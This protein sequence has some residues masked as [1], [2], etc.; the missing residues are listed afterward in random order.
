M[1]KVHFFAASVSTA[2]V[3]D[4]HRNR[5]RGYS[6]GNGHGNGAAIVAGILGAVVIGSLIAN[7]QPA[8]AAPQQYYEPQPQRYHEPQR[9]Q[10]YYG[11]APVTYSNGGY[12][13]RYEQRRYRHRDYDGYYG[14]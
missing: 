11:S 13:D 4:D 10:R 9:V 8:Y 14:R 2:A 1:A 5:H 7:S 6:N 12:A 3:A